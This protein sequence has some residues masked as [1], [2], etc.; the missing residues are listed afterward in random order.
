MDAPGL[1]KEKDTRVVK[2][3]ENCILLILRNSHLTVWSRVMDNI[4][5]IPQVFGKVPSILPL[6]DPFNPAGRR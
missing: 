3:G 1:H 6:E 4:Q 5:E 2:R